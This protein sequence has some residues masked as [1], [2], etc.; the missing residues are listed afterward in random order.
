MKH[1]IGMVLLVFVTL[2]LLLPG[3]SAF[4]SVNPLNLST[5]QHTEKRSFPPDDPDDDVDYYF[6][7]IP[8][9]ATMPSPPSCLGLTIFSTIPPSP[10]YSLQHFTAFWILNPACLLMQTPGIIPRFSSGRMERDGNSRREACFWGP[11]PEPYI[12]TIEFISSL[13][14]FSCSTPMEL[15]KPKTLSVSSSV[16]RGWATLSAIPPKPIPGT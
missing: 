8:G 1:R 2:M 13:E 7:D 3:V 10:K 15:L 9:V 14:T 5:M 6:E 4:M 16:S 12:R 11:S